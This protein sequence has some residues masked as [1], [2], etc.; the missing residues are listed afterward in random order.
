MEAKQSNSKA[1]S[2]SQDASAK[3]GKAGSEQQQD[4][5]TNRIVRWKKRMRYQPQNVVV[6]KKKDSSRHEYYKD[7]V[8]SESQSQ[9]EIPRAICVADKVESSAKEMKAM[10]Q[11]VSQH[12]SDRAVLQKIPRHMRRRAASHNR[13]RLPRRLHQLAAEMSAQ[14]EIH[15]RDKSTKVPNRKKRRR[16]RDLQNE[17]AKRAG[18]HGWLE[19][20]MWHAK[21]FH[22]S[23][24]T[25][26]M[27]RHWGNRVALFPNDKSFRA[28]YR[29]VAKHCLIQDLSYLRCLHLSGTHDHL[30]RLLTG[31]TSQDTKFDDIVL[32]GE[33][34]KEIV[35]YQTTT[36]SS[37]CLGPAY[38][39]WRPSTEAQ[40][41]REA[42]LWIH[43]TILSATLSL[44]STYCQENSLDV[45]ISDISDNLQRFRLTGPKSS[46]S[47][48]SILRPLNYH[49][50]SDEETEITLMEKWMSD[51]TELIRQLHSDFI[52]VMTDCH[53]QVFA[54][55]D[56]KVL[57]ENNTPEYNDGCIFPVI[58]NDPRL[59]LPLD[60]TTPTLTEAKKRLKE[61][62]E[63][64]SC[65]VDEVPS[66]EFL[67]DAYSHDFETTLCK[68][69]LWDHDIRNQVSQNRIPD[70][71]VSTRKRQQKFERNEKVVSESTLNTTIPVIIIRKSPNEGRSLT[72]IKTGTNEDATCQHKNSV[73]S[74]PTGDFA[75]GWDII[76]PSG[77]GT[78]FWIPSIYH[79]VRAGA[80]RENQTTSLECLSPHF[81]KD[82]PDTESGRYFWN[83]EADKLANK[84]YRKPPAKRPNYSVVA[85][86]SPFQ[87]DWNGLFK[88]EQL[89]VSE[90]AATKGLKRPASDED[91]I[92][93]E[94]KLKLEIDID[95][96]KEETSLSCN[97]QKSVAVD[98]SQQENANTQKVSQIYVIRDMKE[99]IS[100]NNWITEKIEY[101]QSP[102]NVQ[103][104]HLQSL[105]KHLICVSVKTL[106]KGIP[107]ARSMLCQPSSDDI[108]N[109]CN[110]LTD[111]YKYGLQSVAGPCEKSHWDPYRKQRKEAKKEAAKRK[112]DRKSENK[113]L[114]SKDI[115]QPVA[116]TSSTSHTSVSVS[117]GQPQTFPVQPSREIIGYV[118]NGDFLF[119]HACG[120]G[121]GFI[122]AQKLQTLVLRQMKHVK[123]Q[124]ILSEEDSKKL[125]LNND[126]HIPLLALMRNTDSLQ[127]RFVK[128]EMIKPS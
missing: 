10:L 90:D 76:L 13:K 113:V 84:Y 112:K 50:P 26:P 43:P 91:N 98:E 12:T 105:S 58:T 35:L 118:T 61:S 68:S 21:R 41:S 14:S 29:A 101:K 127:Y 15:S 125:L 126:S 32:H 60:K 54:R 38:I 33:K 16:K 123:L 44:L 5:V 67:T 40:N 78:A 121:V 45:R 37:V 7:M 66:E 96:E 56:K 36:G 53:R 107:F 124:K 120:A 55:P 87:P 94:K 34:E 89:Q 28:C 65:H 49:A 108:D 4:S 74:G 79:R 77:W 31:V 52:S 20:H 103:M 42:H 80:L 57:L 83:S 97:E 110:D 23:E 73:H 25:D 114:L 111:L 48:L 95:D 18:K 17:F 86:P 100:I 93:S 122:S 69:P 104:D 47:L 46:V 27:F 85:V 24:S 6:N 9:V 39:Y 71:I 116:E 119:S 51:N 102:A 88:K 81:P 117:K 70:H 59:I 92:V 11:A 72:T 75:S 106:N 64:Q 99:I 62:M 30:L 115:T 63:E 82:F 22:M 2:I 8:D 109:L 1:A 128:I 3:V 19:T